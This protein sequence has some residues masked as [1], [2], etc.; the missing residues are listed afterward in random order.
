M[1]KLCLEPRPCCKGLDEVL[2]VLGTFSRCRRDDQAVLG[3]PKLE[4]APPAVVLSAGGGLHWR[5]V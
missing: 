1:G 2:L 5:H 3:G 4:K